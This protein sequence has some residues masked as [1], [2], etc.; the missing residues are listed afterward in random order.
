[1]K[2]L[3]RNLCLTGAVLLLSAGG[4]FAA[5]AEPYQEI[6][7]QA[8]TVDTHNDT[9]MKVVDKATWLPQL[10]IGNPTSL[11]IDIPKLQQGGLKVPFF[12]SYTYP[13]TLNK[14]PDY[15]RANSRILALSNALHWTAGNHPDKMGLA[16]TVKDIKHLV[17]DNKIAAVLT[18]EGAYSL[19]EQNAI[20][21]VRQYYD[22]GVRAIALTWNYSNVLGE[23]AYSVY[24]D[25]RPSDGGL[26]ALGKQVVREMNRLGII[27]DVSHLDVRT[28]WGVIET[29]KAPLIASHSCVYSL[30]NHL[31]N[32][33]DDQIQAIANQGGVVQIAYF[34]E[35]LGSGDNLTIKTVVDHIDYV[36]KLV[37]ADYVGLGS[38]YDGAKM[39]DELDSCAKIPEITREL[40]KRGYSKTD[41][42]KILGG[43]T[44]RVMRE[45]EARADKR[46]PDAK[47]V[48]SSTIRMGEIIGNNKPLLTAEIAKRVNVNADS[49]RV[50]VDGIVYTPQYNPASRVISWQAPSPLTQRFHVV[51]FE[52]DQRSGK[53]ARETKIFYIQ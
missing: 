33:S 30:E 10:D 14:Q 28:F 7:R 3:I 8:I 38:D 47:P 17:K 13:Y 15:G 51:T 44:L 19:N 49:L 21:L 9:M 41:V 4:A 20:E 48:I 26:T 46:K 45:V 6:H 53:T 52:A 18:I 25:G 11:H 42:M 1:M 50:I 16:R 36:V 40:V 35:F 37:G 5:P 12:S 2:S 23:G 39:I 31:R 29:T 24:R 32:L 27:V 34:R 22:L 43:N